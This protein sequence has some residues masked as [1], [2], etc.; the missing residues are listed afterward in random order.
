MRIKFVRIIDGD[1]EWD[2]IPF[3]E[4]RKEILMGRPKKSDPTGGRSNLRHSG[5]R[6][7]G[8]GVPDRFK[9]KNVFPNR[10]TKNNKSIK[11][12]A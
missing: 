3:E 2:D 4:L 1:D 10:K 8:P 12:D 11:P 9:S 6:S 5:K 7:S